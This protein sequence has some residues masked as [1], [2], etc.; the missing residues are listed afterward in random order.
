MCGLA[1]KLVTSNGY[2]QIALVRRRTPR[3]QNEI[4]ETKKKTAGENKEARSRKQTQG[5]GREWRD[6]ERE[7]YGKAVN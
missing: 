6:G 3:S 1:H 2:T 4:M 7:R 5:A